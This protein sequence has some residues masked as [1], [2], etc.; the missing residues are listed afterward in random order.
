MLPLY[1]R[2]LASVNS[3]HILGFR[4]ALAMVFAAG[5]LFACK[6]FS[7]LFFFKNRRSALY[8]VLA[9]IMI[10]FNWG[11]FLWAV[12]AE[13]SLEAA[14]GYYIN[15][16]FVILIGLVFFKEKLKALQWVSLGLALAGVLTIT[17]FTGSPP[18]ISLGLAVSFS[19]YSLLKKL[20]GMPA[21]ESLAI[22]TLIATPP[23]LLLL[24][25]PGI[26]YFFTGLYGVGYVAYLPGFTVLL[27]LL[28]GAIST[29]PLYFFTRAAKL[30][31]LSTLGFIQFLSPTMAF[32]LGYF[33]FREAFPWYNFI[34]FGFIWAAV[35]V[36]VVSLY[37]PQKQRPG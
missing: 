14:F 20:I 31:P 36:F 29:M 7:W 16:L 34:A 22:E 26:S 10:S 23:A 21:L 25:V 11:L 13:R 32:L 30:L 27:L 12:N 4:I 18:L 3:L 8:L 6:N 33:V 9:S 37:A 1:W 35:I 15:P 2:A 5:V 19:T 28:C 24:F 17:I